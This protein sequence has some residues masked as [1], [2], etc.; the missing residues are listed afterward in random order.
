M[1]WILCSMAQSILIECSGF[2]AA[3]LNAENSMHC[4]AMDQS[5]K[6][7]RDQRKTTKLF[8]SGKVQTCKKK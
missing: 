3:S 7:S 6:I 4:G 1:Q 8:N 2:H 5:D